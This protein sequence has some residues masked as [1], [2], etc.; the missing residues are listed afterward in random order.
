MRYF[1]RK[2][3][4]DKYTWIITLALVLRSFIA[5][6]FMLDTS[7]GNRPAIT[8]CNGPAGLFAPVGSY[9]EHSAHHHVTDGKNA[10]HNH[11]TPTCCNWST[12]SMLVFDFFVEEIPVNANRTDNFPYYLTPLFLEYID[13]ARFT[14]GPPLLA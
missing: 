2:R 9:T 8:I 6:G 7:S 12:S 11:I 3:Y 13:P 1:R 5:P 14:R 4:L 10:H